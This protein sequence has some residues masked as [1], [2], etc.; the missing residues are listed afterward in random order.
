[1]THHEKAVSALNARLERLQTNLSAAKSDTAQQFLV[2]SI[3]VSLGINESMT[4]YV[5]TV[6]KYAQR[7]HGEFKQASAKD[8]ARH[9][10]FLKSGSELLEQL[11][12]NPTDRAIRKEIEA[13]K[14]NMTIIQKSLRRGA[15][16][17]QRELAGSVATVDKLADSIR[18][19]CEADHSD[20]LLRAL[21]SLFGNMHELYEA[22]ESMLPSKD[23]IDVA[24]WE[25]SAE[26]EIEKATDFYDAYARA[27]HQAMIALEAMSVA[28]SENPPRTVD[29][30][31]QRANDSVEVRIKDITA[32]LSAA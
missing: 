2:Q 22:L 32:R 25:A 17:L 10:E 9:A 13:A 29:E 15:F 14:R 30:L 27:G 4:E 19:L 11:K 23:L 6:G 26:S 20:V 7:R 24:S 3:V 21:K 28:V 31:I 16:S 8:T 5:K 18:R 1:M 12:A